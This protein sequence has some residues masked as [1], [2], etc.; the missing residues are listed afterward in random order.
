V[1]GWVP[2]RVRVRACVWVCACRCVRARDCVRVYVCVRACARA[3]VRVRALACVSVR[4]RV[5]VCACVR[6]SASTRVSACRTQRA[7]FGAAR[8]RSSGRS[9]SSRPTGFASAR[10]PSANP[11][12]GFSLRQAAEP[13]RLNPQRPINSANATLPQRRLP[14]GIDFSARAVGRLGGCAQ[15]S[16]LMPKT[17]KQHRMQQHVATAVHGR[18][19]RQCGDGAWC[20]HA[21]TVPRRAQGA[22]V[23]QLR[24][25]W[26]MLQSWCN[27]RY[28]W[29]PKRRRVSA[30]DN[31][32]QLPT[33][34]RPP[35]AAA[36][37]AGA[38]VAPA[39]PRA[40]ESSRSQ[41]CRTLDFVGRD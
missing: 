26:C 2:V 37:T 20:N 12:P 16:T 22:A 10:R 36:N 14:H 32:R 29:N 30:A 35:S 31:E 41:R 8:R 18:T 40:D 13:G 5:H 25:N 15:P 21:A 24:L 33:D 19:S 27:G 4:V 23:M 9:S 17:A 11:P 34:T 1:G 7:Q 6:V 28:R 39:C 38:A 3:R